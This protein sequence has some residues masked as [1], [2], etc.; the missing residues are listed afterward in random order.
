MGKWFIGQ[1]GMRR[2]TRLEIN[3]QQTA[4]HGV[5]IVGDQQSGK[6]NAIRHGRQVGL[7]FGPDALTQCAAIGLVDEE[8]DMDHVIGPG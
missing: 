4:M 3:C 2:I 1:P 6:G 5:A 7:V 8:K